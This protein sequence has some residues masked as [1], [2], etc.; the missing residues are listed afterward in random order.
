MF[1]FYSWDQKNHSKK[2]WQ[3]SLEGKSWDV[4]IRQGGSFFKVFVHN[5]FGKSHIGGCNR[6]PLMILG[7]LVFS[8]RCFPLS[9]R[10]PFI[11]P[12]KKAFKIAEDWCSWF[13]FNGPTETK[14]KLDI[15]KKAPSKDGWIFEEKMMRLGFWS[16][17]LVEKFSENNRGMNEKNKKRVECFIFFS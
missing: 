17:I 16:T 14:R 2:R 4:S 1:P 10:G 9:Q 12:P 7:I 5:S 3:A 8:G 15:F 11:S 13:F 6:H